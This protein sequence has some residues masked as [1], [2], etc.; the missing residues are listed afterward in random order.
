MIWNAPLD[1]VKKFIQICFDCEGDVNTELRNC[2]SKAVV[3][4]GSTS[5]NFV[6]QLQALLS[7]FDI[8]SHVYIS[9][10]AKENSNTQYKL[11]IVGGYMCNKF[12]ETI[13]FSMP[14]KQEK[15]H[16]I[17][18]ENFKCPYIYPKV[19]LTEVYNSLE[20]DGR[21]K[22]KDVYSKGK[23]NADLGYR[24]SRNFGPAVTQATI[25]KFIPIAERE[26]IS[27]K[28]IVVCAKINH[29]ARIEE[30]A[31]VYDFT[32]ENTHTF[33]VNGMLSSNCENISPR[34]ARM[35]VERCGKDSKVI[36]LG[37]LSQ[38]E[39]PYLDAKSNGLSHAISGGKKSEL[40]ASVTLSKVERSELAAVA[41]EIFNRPEARRN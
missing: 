18:E 7:K 13:G 27:L 22:N 34:E 15:L 30:Q 25:D 37:D 19:S 11:S 2:V 36:L 23:M 41:S 5:K 32:V 1:S 26:N 21:W 31:T 20:N 17:S 16:S 8:D 24:V 10:T 33:V 9:S 29:I 14:R 4:F 40:V 6:Y 12:A 38:V 28:N 35:V 3:S 39:N